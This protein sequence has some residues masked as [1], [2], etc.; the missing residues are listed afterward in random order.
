[1]APFVFQPNSAESL[2]QWCQEVASA[3]PQLPFCYYHIPSMK[4]VSIPVYEFLKI[5]CDRIPTFHL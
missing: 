1:M 2:V 5:A 4:G 3:A